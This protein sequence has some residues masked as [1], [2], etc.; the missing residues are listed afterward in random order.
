MAYLVP[1]RRFRSFE[2]LEIAWLFLRI[3]NR[4]GLAL[5]PNLPFLDGHKL[6]W[7]VTNYKGV[8]DD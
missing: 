8:D 1:E 7:M 2:I 4:S 3:Q 5:D 6:Y